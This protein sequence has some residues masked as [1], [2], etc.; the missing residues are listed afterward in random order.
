MYE[1]EN[2]EKVDK[3]FRKLSRKDPKQLDAITKKLA[4]LTEDPHRF[5]P[6]SN[7][8]KG[9]RRIHFGSFVLT[10]SI[11]EDRKKVILEDYEHHDKVYRTK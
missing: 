10:F 8:M 6:L 2:S 9:F 7:A 4:E 3:I 11:D 5:K 1:I